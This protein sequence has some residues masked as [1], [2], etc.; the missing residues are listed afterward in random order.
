MSVYDHT[1]EAV[2]VDGNAETKL[3]SA[4]APLPGCVEKRL[5]LNYSSYFE[6]EVSFE[7]SAVHVATNIYTRGEQAMRQANEQTDEPYGD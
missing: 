2:N 5:S 7:K 6:Q 4:G 1:N 3:A